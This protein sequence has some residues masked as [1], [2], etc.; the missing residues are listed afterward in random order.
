MCVCVCVTFRTCMYATNSPPLSLFESAID[1]SAS[2]AEGGTS[3]NPCDDEY[4]G[5]KVS[6][7]RREF[8][9][10]LCVEMPPC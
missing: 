6:K 10:E 5:P 8:E 9:P 2:W 1:F 4:E 7:K 3:G